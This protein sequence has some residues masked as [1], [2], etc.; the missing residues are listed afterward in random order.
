VIA[1]FINA[2]PEWTEITPVF[3][4]ALEDSS[5]RAYG[6]PE[7]M[8]GMINSAA[9]CGGRIV[10]GPPWPNPHDVR[11]IIG[12]DAASRN[13]YARSVTITSGFFSQA[14]RRHATVS[15][16]S[17]PTATLPGKGAGGFAQRVAGFSTADKCLQNHA[18]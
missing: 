17:I 11:I 6:G 1:P 5:K 9:K 7:A 15:S 3:F 4:Q 12:R 10:L 14:F 8:T 13:I 18:C 16:K 2:R